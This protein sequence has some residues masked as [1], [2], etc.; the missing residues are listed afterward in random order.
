[1]PLPSPLTATIRV[2]PASFSIAALLGVISV[3]ASVALPLT[4]NSVA[5]RTRGLA[6]STTIEAARR[7]R[8]V[9]SDTVSN[10]VVGP[11]A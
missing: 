6:D 4:F 11:K 10:P 8:N 5:A 2:N 1:M 9:L 3:P 7:T